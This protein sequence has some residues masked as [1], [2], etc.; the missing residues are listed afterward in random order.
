MATDYI[1][2]EGCHRLARID[3]S[4]YSLEVVLKSAYRFTDRCFV[5]LQR[6]SPNIVEA[7]MRPKR[8]TDDPDAILR[9]FFNDLLDQKLRAVVA[10]ETAGIRDLIMAHALS[11]TNLVRPELETAEPA[12][13]LHHV[14]NPDKPQNAAP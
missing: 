3:L 1:E 6:N 12:E 5:H 13:N 4:V 14:A 10:G 9:E 2:H 8:P 11:R 7:R